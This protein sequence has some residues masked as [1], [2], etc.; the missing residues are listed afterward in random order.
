LFN[1]IGQGKATF[2]EKD[3]QAFAREADL[4][5]DYVKPFYSTFEQLAATNGTSRIGV[6]YETFHRYVSARERALKKVFDTLDAGEPC[7]LVEAMSWTCPG[8]F[9]GLLLKMEIVV[10]CARPLVSF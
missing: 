10:P 2:T 9:S 4:P 7:L 5:M 3:V 6:D 1:Q 8:S